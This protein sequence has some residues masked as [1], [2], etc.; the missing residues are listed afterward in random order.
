MKEVQEDKVMKQ[1]YVEAA[2]KLSELDVSRLDESVIEEMML[3]HKL[4]EELSS[5]E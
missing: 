4:A 3:F 2:K 5:N 1:R